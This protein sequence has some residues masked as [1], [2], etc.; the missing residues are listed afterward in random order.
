MKYA[1]AA[2][3]AYLA[4]FLGECQSTLRSFRLLRAELAGKP[5]GAAP[6]IVGMAHHQW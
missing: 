6:K 5:L 2:Y 3:P 1:L 4:R